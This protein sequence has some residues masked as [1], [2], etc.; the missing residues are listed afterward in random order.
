MLFFF[1]SYGAMDMLTARWQVC[2]RPADPVLSPPGTH[3]LRM[4]EVRRQSMSTASAWL[5]LPSVLPLAGDGA[6]AADRGYQ[7]GGAGA[8]GQWRRL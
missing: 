4:H 7:A 5:V 3:I 8:E 2:T 6:V 1:P